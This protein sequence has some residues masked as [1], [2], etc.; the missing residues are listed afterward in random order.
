MIDR[1]KLIEGLQELLEG[2]QYFLLVA[3]PI[4]V[5]FELEVNSNMDPGFVGL[6]LENLK[7]AIQEMSE[8]Q[9]RETLTTPYI[10][11]N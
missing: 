6:M 7:D 2:R 11:R 5:G 8:G 1:N 9:I 10:V 3:E 4:K